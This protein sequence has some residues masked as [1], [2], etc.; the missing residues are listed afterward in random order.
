M[1]TPIYMAFFVLGGGFGHVTKDLSSPM[2]ESFGPRKENNSLK[3]P[4]LNHLT[5]EKT[6]HNFSSTLMLQ[7]S[8][9]YLGLTT[10]YTR[11]EDLSPPCPTASVISTK[12]Y[13]KYPA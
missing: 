5:S 13:S 7:A 6:K 1:D 8:C 10:P 2:K 4:L 3:G 9:S 12:E 11:P